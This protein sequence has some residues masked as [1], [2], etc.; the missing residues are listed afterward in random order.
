MNLIVRQVRIEDSFN[1]H[2]QMFEHSI[3]S[4]AFTFYLEEII[5]K[6]FATSVNLYYVYY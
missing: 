6:I 5:F 3:L 2:V 1:H 4:H